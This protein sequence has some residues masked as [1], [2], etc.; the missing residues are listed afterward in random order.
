MVKSQMIASG[1]REST[2]EVFMRRKIFFGIALLVILSVYIFYLNC[3]KNSTRYEPTTDN[4]LY[5]SDM[6][7]SPSKKIYV[8]STLTDSLIDS[9]SLGSN[10]YPNYLALSPDK[11][12]LYATVELADTLG[13][14]STYLGCEIDTRTKTIKYLG[15]N[16]SP[17][18]SPDGR[19]LFGVLG[20][21]FKIFDASTH[22]MV[23]QDTTPYYTPFCF[24]KNAHLAYGNCATDVTK[25]RVFDYE[26]KRWIRIFSIRLGDGSIPGIGRFIISPDGKTLY[27]RVR[28]PN[29]L[30]YFC[31]YDLTKDTLLVQLG[32]N[33]ANGDLGLKPDG[34]TVYLT[35]PGEG[36]SCL[37]FE[38]PPSGLLGVFD[39]KTNTLLPSIPLNVFTD[40]LGLPAP[41][42]DFIVITPDGRKAYLDVCGDWILVID[43]T[44]NEP[45][46]SIVVPNRSLHFIAL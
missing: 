23:Y 2:K 19:Y 18:L 40:S 32:L 28:A 41:G 21:D 46:K 8:F 29:Y 3:T 30:D 27:L 13:G 31:V 43:L 7:D 45:L 12:T 37:H 14:S 9:I 5:A 4:F 22:E 26:L 17:I 6:G 33:T 36:G 10:I 39:A 24:N 34:S 1:L 42:P 35:D 38:P 20:K 44:K 15:P 11:R 16:T 25:I